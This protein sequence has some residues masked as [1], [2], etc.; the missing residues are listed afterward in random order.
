MNIASSNNT[1]YLRDMDMVAT[2]DLSFM[3]GG[4]EE[5]EEA[6]TPIYPTA[7]RSSKSFYSISRANTKPATI[8]TGRFSHAFTGG[9]APSHHG[10]HAQNYML[11][12]A[13]GTLDTLPITTASS[14][15]ARSGTADSS[16]D[17]EEPLMMSISRER[18]QGLQQ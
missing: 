18:R 7:T 8:T 5:A 6:S 12:Y 10:H 1:P 17:I 4:D 13:D 15:F 3:P 16:S 9:V 2:S 14:A 11:R